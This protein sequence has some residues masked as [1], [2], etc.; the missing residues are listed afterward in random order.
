MWATKSA[1][2]SLTGLAMISRAVPHCTIRPPSISAMRLPIL[3]ASSRSWLTKTMVRF[4]LACRSRSSSCSLDADQRVQRRE[5]LVHQEDRRVGDKGAGQADALLHAAR[6][7]A[8]LALGPLRS[9]S[10]APAGHRPWARASGDMPA[11]S[12][13]RPTFS[14]TVRQGSRPNCWNTMAIRVARR[15]RSVAGLA[16]VT[17]TI[18]SPSSTRTSPRTT[19]FSAFTPRRSVDLPEPDRPISTRISP[20]ATVRRAVVHAK[21]LAGCLLD[22]G[23]GLALVHQ[24]QGA[25]RGC[26]RRRWRRGRIRRRR[27]GRSSFAVTLSM[28]S[29]R[30]AT[31]T[32][33]EAGFEAQRGIDAGSAPAPPAR[34]GRWRRP[35]RDHHHR[36]RQHDGL[37][38]PGHDLRQ[39]PGQFHLPQPLPGVA[40]KAVAASRSAVGVEADAQMRQPDRARAGRRSRWRSGPAPCRGRK[41]TMAGIR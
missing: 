24:R 25:I 5:R 12:S 34:Q 8:H 30:M 10:P 19:G 32:I 39:G 37:V 40:P 18:L 2:Y 17:E 11:S 26:R 36:Q 35:G 6:Q 22:F 28:R 4:S 38:Q 14:R 41:K 1:T 3:K 31:T 9:G 13:P 16:L 7:F 29:S 20:S 33:T 27:E 21:H 15:R 23:P